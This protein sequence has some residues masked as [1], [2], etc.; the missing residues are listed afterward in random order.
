MSKSKAKVRKP[1]GQ[2][3]RKILHQSHGTRSTQKSMPQP[4]RLEGG[5]QDSLCFPDWYDRDGD[6]C[7][8]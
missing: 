8:R 1:G 5:D 3:S 7:M 4:D 2:L 6:I